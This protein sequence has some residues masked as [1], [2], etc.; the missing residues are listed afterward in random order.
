MF[1]Y[2]NNFNLLYT[3]TLPPS[4]I[5]KNI[6]FEG[7]E[8]DCKNLWHKLLYCLS[9]SGNIL[10]SDKL[11]NIRLQDESLNVF[12]KRARKYSYEYERVYFFDDYRTY[13]IPDNLLLKQNP[14]LEIRDWLDV[15]S[16]MKHE[17]HSITSDSPFV[18]KIFFYQ[19][20]RIDGNHDLKDAVAISYLTQ[21]QLNDFEYSDVNARFK[22]KHIMKGA[23]IKGTRNGRDTKNKLIYKYYAIRLEN[24][25]REVVYKLKNYKSTD[26]LIFKYDSVSDT[27][28]NEIL[29][30]NARRIFNRH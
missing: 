25:K 23:G 20:D 21:E 13:S 28:N 6:S 29:D 26:K 1:A 19:S 15:K 12:T 27:I 17:H 5:E 8:Y 11:D 22:T 18:N 4:K 2:Q 24:K 10:F 3:R 14:V 7:K 9:L 16:G 30:S